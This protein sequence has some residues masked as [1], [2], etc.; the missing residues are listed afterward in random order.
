MM[1]RTE[2]SNWS[3][4][5]SARFLGPVKRLP[6][7][8]MQTWAKLSPPSCRAAPAWWVT[9]LFLMPVARPLTC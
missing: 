9:V 1:K 3:P 2:A 8:Q 5:L 6:G 4:G 7:N